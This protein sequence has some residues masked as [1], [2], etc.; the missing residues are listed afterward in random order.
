[1]SL[2]VSTLFFDMNSFFASV[3]QQ[4][5]PALMG[6]PVG[7]LTTDA[8]GA[9][10]IA[11]S[12]E[13]KRLGIRMGT[14][15]EEARLLCPQI[16]FRPA[17]HDVCVAYHHAIRAAVDTVLPIAQAHS[18]DEFTCHLM[19]RQQELDTA[20]QI[21]RAVQ[22]AILT[23]VG[24]AM[25]SSVGVAPNTRLAKI[26]AELEKPSGVNWLHP[27]VLPD[28]IAHLALKDLPGISHGIYPRLVQAG[29]TDIR[30]LYTM[31]PKQA[32]HLWGN[33]TGEKFLRELHG[34]VVDWTRQ[35]NQS[36]GHGQRLTASNRS[37]EGARLVA[38]RL[39]VKAASRL[40]RQGAL[41]GS[42]YLHAK[43]AQNGRFRHYGEIQP[44]QDSF[45]LLAIFERYWAGFRLRR[46]VSVGVTLG[47]LVPLEQH[48]ADLFEDRPAG[49]PTRREAL[50][51]AIDGL[52]QRFGQDTITYGQ[53]PPHRVP[54]TGAKIAFHRIPDPVEFRE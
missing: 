51:Q 26:A 16:V 35:A 32:R 3:A 5:E 12:I 54:Y 37:P 40:R 17:K 33:V 24:A 19:G 9:A 14:R 13:A 34:E 2:R 43:C 1:M 18:V 7:V 21:A 23:R 36:I 47:R 4:E 20:L 11:A 52:N 28:K 31:T 30:Q 29:I 48:I 45:T 10:C 49:Q 39:L 6:R 41:A 53:L 46:P 44:T 42:L 25:R 50:C 8:P 38:R 15:Q 22:Q 27:S